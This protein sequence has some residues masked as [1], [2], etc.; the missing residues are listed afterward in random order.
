MPITK[1][2]PFKDLLSIQERMNR[3][4]ET[5]LSRSDV[6]ALGDF[7]S[8]SP[9][10]DIYETEENLVISMELPGIREGEIDIS[11]TGDTLTIRGERK[12]DKEVQKES[13]HR[14]ERAYGA[15]SRH[16]NI[17]AGLETGK[18]SASFKDGILTLSIPRKEASKPKKI[19]I[20]VD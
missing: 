7:A 11:I 19:K 3:L 16:F 13:Y 15:F 17:P 4:F 20:K 8:W 10:A 5:A 14:I 9:L 6:A 2:D 18:V 1:W 12:M